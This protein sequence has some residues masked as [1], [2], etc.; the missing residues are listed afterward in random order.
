[1]DRN[2]KEYIQELRN[3]LRSAYGYVKVHEYEGLTRNILDRMERLVPEV[4]AT[5]Q[6]DNQRS[7]DAK[8]DD[9]R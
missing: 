8:T 3:T 6:H 2:T 5:T 4:L 1:M 7:K 9:P